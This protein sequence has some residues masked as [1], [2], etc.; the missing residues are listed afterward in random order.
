M[1]TGLNINVDNMDI[2]VMKNMYA[3]KM[4]IKH[5]DAYIIELQHWNKDENI[6]LW[7]DGFAKFCYNY[8]IKQ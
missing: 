3:E 8:G 1:N 7:Y 6:R 5:F 4:N 2:E